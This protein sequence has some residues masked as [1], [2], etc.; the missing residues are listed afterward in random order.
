[1]LRIVISFSRSLAARLARAPGEASPVL[2]RPPA[3]RVG[4]AV[5]IGAAVAA[6]AVSSGAVQPILAALGHLRRRPDL[7]A[8]F[9]L[10]YTGGFWLR[11]IAWRRLLG[12]GP[13]IG[14]LFLIQLVALAVNHL[15][16]AKAGD[17]ARGLLLARE[18]VPGRQAAASIIGARLL[19]LASLI[20][21]AGVGAGAGALG[22]AGCAIGPARWAGPHRASR[23]APPGWGARFGRYGEA[24]AWAIPSWALEAGVLWVAAQALAV[25]L[26]GSAVLT[27][28]ALTL[29]AQVFHFSPGGLGTY[30]AA[31]TFSLGRFGVPAETGL[32]LAVL[33]HG[34]KFAYAFAAGALAWLCVVRWGKSPPVTQP[35]AAPSR[36]STRS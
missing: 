9:L 20:C 34:L 19:D 27:A 30:E 6:W 13:P 18:G 15:L 12:A 8:L 5:A 7:V 17:V 32:A 1:M 25:P 11:S 24:L 2:L 23:S 22:W 29:L 4:L 26:A 3:W 28:T 33:T 36:R 31:M 10:T 21:L 16:P 14:R 35:G